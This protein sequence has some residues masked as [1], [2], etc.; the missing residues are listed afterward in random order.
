MKDVFMKWN[1]TLADRIFSDVCCAINLASD[2]ASI[3][4]CYEQ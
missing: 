2:K 4:L 1:S 3:E